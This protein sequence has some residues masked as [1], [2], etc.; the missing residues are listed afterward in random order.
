MS[1]VTHH[2]GH[3]TCTT[4]CPGPAA[5]RRRSA[6]S[7]CCAGSTTSTSTDKAPT[8]SPS[9]PTAD[10]PYPC[11]PPRPSPRRRCRGLGPGAQEPEECQHT[12]DG[13]GDDDDRDEHGVPPF[14]VSVRSPRARR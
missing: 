14:L 5:D 4:L 12:N 3:V 11:A 2:R 10:G 9:G 7:G 13:K 6:T 8:T 1:D